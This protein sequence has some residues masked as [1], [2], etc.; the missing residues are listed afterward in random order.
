MPEFKRH[1][2]TKQIPGALVNVNFTANTATISPNP[3][4]A[5]E[6]WEVIQSGL[7]LQTFVWRGYIDL[8]GWSVE[9]LTTF[10]QSVDVQQ[11]FH[12]I[13]SP[14]IINVYEYDFVTSRRLTDDE[15]GPPTTCPGF[16]PSTLDFQ[17]CIYGQ[18][19]NLLIQLQ[20]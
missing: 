9:D 2:L 12:T 18:W 13:A 1:Q 3:S 11:S 15:V 6:G 5:A 16:S 17:Q 20:K 7:N 14:N 19:R 10:V 4:G 8:A